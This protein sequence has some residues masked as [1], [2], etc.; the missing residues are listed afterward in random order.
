MPTLED[1]AARLDGTEQLRLVALANA[2]SIALGK[3]YP[4]AE[5]ISQWAVSNVVFGDVVALDA[6]LDK[7]QLEEAEQLLGTLGRRGSSPVIHLRRSRLL[8]YQDKA[9]EAVATVDAALREGA[10]TQRALVE[11]VY[12]LLA[13]DN[14]ASARE[15]LTRYASVLG[16]S[17]EWLKALVDFA[18][19]NPR[20]AK[21]SV[22]GLEAPPAEAPLLQRVLAARTLAAVGDRRAKGEIAPLL[23]TFSRNPDVVL[24]G[25]AVGLVR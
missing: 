5:A 15:L 16:A 18:S 17:A 10:P 3:K 20:R 2:P 22:A 23:R 8:R 9:Q 1:T 12:A 7:G 14:T 4:N 13:A 11:A 6:L 19:N 21:A 24:A 25:K